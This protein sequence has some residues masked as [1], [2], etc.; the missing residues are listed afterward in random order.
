MALPGGG[1]R[2]IEGPQFGHCTQV[3]AEWTVWR[4]GT[5]NSSFLLCYSEIFFSFWSFSSAFVLYVVAKG[6]RSSERQE[7]LC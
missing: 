4:V 2:D 3:T 6:T 7:V 5:G 1:N